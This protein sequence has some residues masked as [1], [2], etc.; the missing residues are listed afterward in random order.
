MT[1][2]QI[3]RRTALAAAVAAVAFTAA[4]TFAAGEEEGGSCC[5][6][7]SAAA[8]INAAPADEEAAGQA[9]MSADD[10]LAK[11]KEA[12]SYQEAEPILKDFVA[13]YPDHEQA[14]QFIYALA[15]NTTD[16]AEQ[17]E[18]YKQLI[19]LHPDTPYAAAAEG[20]IKKAESVGKPFEL[21]FEELRSGNEINLQ[22]DLAGKVVVIDFWATWCG[23]CIAEMP[24]MKKL[25]SEYKD[26]GVEFVGISLDAPPSQG[27]RDKLLAYVEENDIAW[28]QYYQGNGW[29]SDFSKGW[30]INSIPAVFIVDADG[31]LHSVNARGKL[32]EMIPELIAKRDGGE[33]EMDQAEDE[34][35]MAQ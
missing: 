22:E 12:K 35:A 13:A 15:G 29:D 31:K 24:T 1:S 11:L 33:A 18:Y 3:L 2:N 25:Y 26:Q 27:G 21:K 6:A 9:T 30:G 34:A 5:A 23:P 16:E 32:E 4:P 17:M 20:Q 8:F 19:D 7:P 10:M 14:A 28:P